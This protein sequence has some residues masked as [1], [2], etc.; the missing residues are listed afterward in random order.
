MPTIPSTAAYGRRALL[1]AAAIALTGAMVV[2]V[3]SLDATLDAQRASKTSD[4]PDTN[5][6]S[7]PTHSTPRPAQRPVLTVDLGVCPGIEVRGRR[8]EERHARGG[9][10][11]GFDHGRLLLEALD[12]LLDMVGYLSD[13]LVRKDLGV[14]VGF[15]HGLGVIGPRRRQGRVA[16]LFETEAQRSQLLGRSQRPWTKTTGVRPVALLAESLVQSGERLR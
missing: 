12:D 5:R 13:R 14:R 7:L 6:C 15:L 9:N 11:E 16:S 3:L 10:G 1:L 2:V 8:H 4:F